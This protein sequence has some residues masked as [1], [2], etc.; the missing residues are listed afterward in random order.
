[1]NGTIEDLR[2]TAFKVPTDSPESDGTLEW[3]AT[4]LVLV[5]AFDGK[6]AGI[7]CTCSHESCA[8]LIRDGLDIRVCIVEMPAVNTPQFGWVKHRLP[9]RAQ[10]VP[11][12][13]LKDAS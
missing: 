7:G 1:L 2:A 3:G 6:T 12:I 5:R 4:T 13:Y 10:P 9:N 11:P 8:P